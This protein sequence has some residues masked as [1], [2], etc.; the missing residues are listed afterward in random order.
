MNKLLGLS[1]KTLQKIILLLILQILL[2][3]SFYHFSFIR[4]GAG[5]LGVL[6]RPLFHGTQMDV[7]YGEGLHFVL[8]INNMFIYNVRKQTETFTASMLTK[9]GLSVDIDFIIRY[10]VNPN[11]LP[12]LHKMTGPDYLNK[13]IQPEAKHAINLVVSEYSLE[14]LWNKKAPHIHKKV[15][16]IL[17]KKWN[18]EFIYI[19]DF[20]IKEVRAPRY[21]EDSIEEKIVLMENS[22]RYEWL[23][24]EE[25]SEI[26]RK[27]LE[28]TSI[29]VFQETIGSSLSSKILKWKEIDAALAISKA[30]NSELVILSNDNELPI[31]HPKESRNAH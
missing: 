28:A 26:E 9:D 16:N 14:E 30:S 7:V 5:E 27:K 20:T 18:R 6:Y 10:Y 8:P 17:Q 4:I 19:D 25:T 24:K 1:H 2:V 22:E 11:K 31:L 23:I 3:P 13:V 12:F 21:V 29:Q 15:L